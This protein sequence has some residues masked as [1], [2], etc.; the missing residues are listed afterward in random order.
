[1]SQSTNSDANR[2]FRKMTLHVFLITFVGINLVYIFDKMELP[3][4]LVLITVAVW[5]VALLTFFGYGL[6]NHLQDFKKL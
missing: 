6:L 1:M 3:I 2:W 4:I 5:F